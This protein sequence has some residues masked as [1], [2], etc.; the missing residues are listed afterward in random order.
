MWKSRTGRLVL[1]FAVLFLSS[2]ALIS[3][4][5]RQIL[6]PNPRPSSTPPVL[7]G[8]GQS[9][10]V[11]TPVGQVE[12]IFLPAI[13][14]ESV[15]TGKSGPLV[16]YCHGNGELIEHQ[17]RA[18]DAFRANG[19]AVLLAE[20][21]GYGHSAGTPSERS[22]RQ[23]I[24]A[25]YDWGIQQPGVQADQVIGY[26]RS[27]GGGAICTLAKQRPLSAVI[28]EST[29]TSVPEVAQT[30]FGPVSRIL[31]NKFDNRSVVAD[32]NVPVLILHGREDRVIPVSHGEQLHQALPDSTLVLLDCD[33]NDCRTAGSLALQFLSEHF[34]VLADS[35]PTPVSQ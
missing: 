20:Y 10:R 11:E 6:F 22:I 8:G 25:I 19:F 35:S 21:P 16:I 27:L 28:L 26:G 3:S 14:A 1:I 4:L 31:R 2:C 34:P 12:A 24:A 32:L 18:F 23:A 17:V 30:H 29:F 7:P 13:G 9:V 33:H 5:E 15:T